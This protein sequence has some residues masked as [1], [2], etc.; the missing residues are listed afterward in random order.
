LY[1]YYY[2]Y[3]YHHHHH[4]PRYH[5]YAGDL[6]LYLN[7]TMFLGHM[8]LHL[9]CIYNLC[10]IYVISPLIYVVY[11]YI[12][13]FRSMC[14]VPNMTVL[15]SSLI[16]RLPVMLLRYCL[17]DFEI[18]PGPPLLLA[19][20]LLSLSTFAEFLLQGLCIVLVLVLP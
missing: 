17:S 3:Y 9:F 12:S 15:C 1:Y 14:A 6:Q 18:V 19:S 5:L 7:Q 16:S 2:Y 10:Y 13:T 4:H 8:G 11:F 20:L